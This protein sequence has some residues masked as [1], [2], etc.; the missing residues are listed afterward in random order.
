MGL[1]YETGI[2]NT[3]QCTFVL[4]YKNVAFQMREKVFYR[5]ISVSKRRTS[6][7]S[8]FNLPESETI[9]IIVDKDLINGSSLFGSRG[10][11]LV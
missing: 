7:L 9:D 8:F 4:R 5:R 3:S 2:C 10:K 6:V 11:V 1:V